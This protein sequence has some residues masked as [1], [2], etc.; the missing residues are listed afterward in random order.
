MSKSSIEWG[1]VIEKVLVKD[2]I[3]S[4]ELQRNLSIVSTTRRLSESKI[5][6]AKADL[7][8]AKL[9]R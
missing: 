8:S 9:Y 3:M 1:V 4:P 5:I 7:E 2:I 6:S